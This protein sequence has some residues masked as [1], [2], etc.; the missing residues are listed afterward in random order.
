MQALAQVVRRQVDQYHFV[1]GVKKG[2]GHCFPHLDAGH[3]A[4]HVVQAFEMLNVNRSEH[5]NAGFK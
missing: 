5:V 1:C 2:I 3:T 4:D